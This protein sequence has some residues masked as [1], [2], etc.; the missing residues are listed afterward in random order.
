MA[1]VE[2]CESQ[3]VKWYKLDP[4]C[5]SCVVSVPRDDLGHNTP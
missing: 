2:V 5:D 3:H 1:E 4:I